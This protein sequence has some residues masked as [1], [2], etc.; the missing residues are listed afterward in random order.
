[1]LTVRHLAAVPRWAPLTRRLSSFAAAPTP[2][3][4]GVHIVPQQSAYVV[5]RF[6]KF[7]KVLNAGI[8]LLVPLVDRVAYVHV[9]KEVRAL[10]LRATFPSRRLAVQAVDRRVPRARRYARALRT[11]RRRSQCR[12]RRRSRRTT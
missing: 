3:N 6:G 9:L 1:M 2:V 4:L 5:E 11:R 7:S 10:L 8:H 12:R